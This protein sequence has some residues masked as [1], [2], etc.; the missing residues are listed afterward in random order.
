MSYSKRIKKLVIL[1]VMLSE[2]KHLSIYVCLS[3]DAS[4]IGIPE[5]SI[6]SRLWRDAP[7]FILVRK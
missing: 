4:G 7:K 1:H 3:I 5:A 2:A 6:A